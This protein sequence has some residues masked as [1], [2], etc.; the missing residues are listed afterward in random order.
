MAITVTNANM[1]ITM[2][3]TTTAAATTTTDQGHVTNVVP[4]VCYV[5]VGS[6]SKCSHEAT[7]RHVIL[8]SVETAQAEV[9]VQLRVAYTHL[10]QT[11]NT[12]QLLQLQQKQHHNNYNYY[13]NQ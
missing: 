5:V 13:N 3:T 9:I 6:N 7:E 11:P 12:Q 1:A 2:T 8:L 4:D 10:Q